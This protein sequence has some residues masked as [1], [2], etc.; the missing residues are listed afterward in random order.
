MANLQQIYDAARGYLNDTQVPGGETCTNTMLQVNFNEP[1]RRMYRCLQGISKRIQRVVYI[2]LPANSSTVLIPS[3]YGLLDFAEPELIEERPAS[4][5]VTIVSTSNATPIVCN[6]PAHGLGNAGSMLEGVIS[7]V[8]GSTAPWGRW[9]VTIV[10]ANNFSL[11]GSVKDGAVGVGGVFTPWN[12]LQFQP[13]LPLDQYGQGLDGV[14]QQYL[15]NYIWEEE[16]LNF[17]GCVGTQQ[18]RITYWAFGNPPALANLDINI[19]DSIDFLACATAANAARALGWEPLATNL[20]V[21]AYGAEQEA[22]GEGGLLGEF[23]RIQVQAMQRGPQRRQ[24]AFRFRR[25]RFGE[26]IYY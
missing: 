25:S 24:Q 7:G 21:T 20:K 13:V 18:L 2:N 16:R 9:Y 3:A 23:V 4:A 14:P 19:S 1:Y 15:G 10:D 17:R 8:L 26:G 12:Q 5:S 11:N 22:N 6:A